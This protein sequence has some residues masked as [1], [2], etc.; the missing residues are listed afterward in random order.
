MNFLP[1]GRKSPTK[2]LIYQTLP[3]YMD[4]LNLRKHKQ[5]LSLALSV[6]KYFIY[7]CNL[8]EDPLLFS[9]FKWQFRENILT[10]GYIAMKNKTAM[11][12]N[13][14]IIK[15]FVLEI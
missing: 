14:F 12:F 5:V 2:K 15:D 9:L 1:F 6:A 4:L 8:A 10:E 11:L 3:F 7:K 13:D